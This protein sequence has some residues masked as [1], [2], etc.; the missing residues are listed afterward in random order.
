M[1]STKFTVKSVGTQLLDLRELGK[2]LPCPILKHCPLFHLI[3]HQFE[4]AISEPRP[5]PAHQR[6]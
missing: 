1:C 3:L 5:D 6:H 4:Q 2:K